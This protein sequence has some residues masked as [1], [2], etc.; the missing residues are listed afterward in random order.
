MLG[1]V[2]TAI[3]LPAG[4]M[5]QASFALNNR[6]GDPQGHRIDAPVTDAA[7]N[8][9]WGPQWR[10]EL[11]GGR[12]S[13][14]LH[15]AIDFDTWSRVITSLRT[16]GYFGAG[17]DGRL[18]ILD[19]PVYT[20]AYLQIKVWDMGLG[21]T[22]EEAAAQG[23]GGYGQSGL[24]YAMGRCGGCVTPDVP[25]ILVGLQS[26]SVLPV[27]PEPSAVWLLGGG[28]AALWFTRRRACL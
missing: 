19:V 11:Y 22:Y 24:V 12:T 4:A 10:V 17:A 2:L 16:P 8:L 25:G 21:A 28:L 23:L 9:L 27:V 26:F 15:P 7:G 1:L 5:A 14:S 18:V 3:A 13:D 20:W 6:A